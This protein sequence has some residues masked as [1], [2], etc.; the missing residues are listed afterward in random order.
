ANGWS[1]PT[2][3]FEAAGAGA[4]L[5]TDAWEGIEEFLEPEQ[6]VLVAHDGADVARHLLELTPERAR[7]IG[8]AARER[9]LEQ[10]TYDR[11]AD[12]V[13]VGS[14]VPEGVQVADWVLDVARGRVVFYDIDTPVTLAKLR[15]GDREYLSPELIPRFDAYLSFAGG[16]ALRELERRWHARKALA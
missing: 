16:P 14:Y 6:E 10:H 11:R 8:A 1:P 12:L 3:V 2:R 5:I 15:A 4:C 7:A 9:L 13:V